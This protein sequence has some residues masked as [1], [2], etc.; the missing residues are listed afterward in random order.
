MTSRPESSHEEH[1]KTVRGDRVYLRPPCIG[2]MAKFL[3]IVDESRVLHSP[4]VSP[5]S[6]PER[7]AEYVERAADPSYIP[8]LLCTVPEDR[9]AGAIN[10][11]NICYGNFRNACIGFWIGVH[12]RGKGLMSDGISL[13]LALAFHRM[14]LHRVEANVQPGNDAS[15]KVLIRVGFRLEGMSP[16]F[17]NIGGEWKDHERWAICSEEFDV[18]STDYATGS[19]AP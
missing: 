6:T 17:L 5:A 8:L 16:R 18:S 1:G 9:I 14:D 3:R 19:S 12:D 13:A 4:W 7:F 11:S 2:D 15:K 10:L